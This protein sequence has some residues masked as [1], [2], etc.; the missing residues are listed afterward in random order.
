MGMDSSVSSF[1]C[2]CWQTPCWNLS[3]RR[4]TEM[5]TV[6]RALQMVGEEVSERSAKKM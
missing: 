5:N 1:F 4:G 6:G 3:H 2:A